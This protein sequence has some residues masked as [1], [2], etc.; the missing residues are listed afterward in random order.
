MLSWDIIFCYNFS[1]T[2]N[3]I[4]LRSSTLTLDS[5]T[6]VKALS[7]TQIVESTGGS[8]SGMNTEQAAG[9]TRH[10]SSI[11]IIRLLN[12][13][14]VHVW[15][16]SVSW[17]QMSAFLHTKSTYVSHKV[18]CVYWQVIYKNKYNMI[19]RSIYTQGKLYTRVTI[20][21]SCQTFHSICAHVRRSFTGR[22]LLQRTPGITR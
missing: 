22:P 13:L 14:T 11:L 7:R 12:I 3:Q 18:Q 1:T 5:P 9:V 15:L 6:S 16:R 2:C 4:F 20:Q 8:M 17:S 10:R 19:C 21:L